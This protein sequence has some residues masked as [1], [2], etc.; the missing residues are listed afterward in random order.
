MKSEEPIK[1]FKLEA[2]DPKTQQQPVYV[3]EY[4]NQSVIEA[5]AP[6]RNRASLKVEPDPSKDVRIKFDGRDVVVPQGK[7]VAQPRP[8]G[9]S[10]SFSQ[11]RVRLRSL[12]CS[13]LSADW[14]ACRRAAAT[15]SSAAALAD[16]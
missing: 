16:L 14:R 11:S 6:P 15:S 8:E 7:P 9:A 2:G 3:Q 10:S 4:V 5:Y 13:E 12:S 1:N